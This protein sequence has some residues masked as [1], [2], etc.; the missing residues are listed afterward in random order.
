MSDTV[1]QVNIKSDEHP[2]DQPDPG[3]QRQEN[4]HKKA[5]ENA[6]NGNQG[7]YWR[8]KSA[9]RIRHIF[10]H[11]QYSD[12][13]QDKSEQSADA[14]HFTNHSGWNKCS[15][16]TNENHEQEITLKWRSEFRVHF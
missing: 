7:N 2:N 4:H 5:G 10:S 1:P 8:F 11:H 13:N 16:K 3:I 9:R 14:C 12:T 6:Q 15:K